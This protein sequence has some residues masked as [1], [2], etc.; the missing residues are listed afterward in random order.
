MAGSLRMYAISKVPNSDILG[1]TTTGGPAL[2]TISELNRPVASKVEWI[3]RGRRSLLFLPNGEFIVEVKFHQHLQ[4]LLA[5]PASTASDVYLVF[6]PGSLESFQTGSLQH[7]SFY[8]QGVFYHLSAPDLSRDTSG[9]SPRSDKFRDVAC[10]LRCEDLSNV[11]LPDYI[12][13]CNSPGRKVL[14]AYK[15]GQTDYRSDQILLLAEW[16][17]RQLSVY[18]LFAANCQHF[19]TTMVRRTVMRMGDRSAFAGTAT[20][21]VDWDLGRESQP[22][23]N[24]LEHGFLIAP[25]LPGKHCRNLR[26]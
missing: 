26:W 12:R 5:G 23:V 22:H 24:C 17:V 13:L 20:Q 9:K 4:P 7:C 16:A 19:A 18:G 10:R 8:T 21:I 14:V 25:P 2:P 11:S 1:D 15:V 6:R 3:W